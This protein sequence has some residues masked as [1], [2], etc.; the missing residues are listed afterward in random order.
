MSK[1]DRI[2]AK[3][4]SDLRKLDRT[5]FQSTIRSDPKYQ[6]GSCSSIGWIE[7]A[8][9]TS[10]PCLVFRIFVPFSGKFGHGHHHQGEA[11]HGHHH[12]G[13][14]GH[15]A[16]HKGEFGHGH[17]HHGEAKHG[18]HHHGEFGHGHKHHGHVSSVTLGIFIPF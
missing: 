18:H 13:E 2:G 11:K 4:R 1:M 15:E 3:F 14:F 16:H 9:F 10:T 5:A 12:H 17:K 7:K 6:I 8:L